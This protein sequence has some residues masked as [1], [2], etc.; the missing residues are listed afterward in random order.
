MRINGISS[1]NINK[2][3]DNK[4]NVQN[5]INNNYNYDNY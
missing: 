4:Q 1:P 5:P 2:K 3:F